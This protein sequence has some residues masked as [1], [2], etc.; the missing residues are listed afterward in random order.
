MI[1]RVLTELGF[2]VL[3]FNVEGKGLVM[4]LGKTIR[5]GGLAMRGIFE[6]RE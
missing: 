4:R 1:E 6:G 5:L 2:D 3:I